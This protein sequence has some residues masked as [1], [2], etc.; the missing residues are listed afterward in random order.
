[1]K[2]HEIISGCVVVVVVDDAVVYK[3]VFSR[4]LTRYVVP[5]FNRHLL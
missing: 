1:M 4:S 2:P 5:M 3:F